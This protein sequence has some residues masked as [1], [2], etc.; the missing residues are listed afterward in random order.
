MDEYISLAYRRKHLSDRAT[1]V[2]RD[3]Q[4]NIQNLQQDI[5]HEW[6][7][8]KQSAPPGTEV[9]VRAPVND[10][11][12][13]FLRR[14]QGLRPGSVTPNR[15]TEF[16]S[17]SLSPR[18]QERLFRLAQ[19][20]QDTHQKIRQEHT[21]R[22]DRERKRQERRQELQAKKPEIDAEKEKKRARARDSKSARE[23]AKRVRRTAER[24]ARDIASS[25]E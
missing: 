23:Y 14:V 19:D 24:H 10:S 17:Q 21:V 15:V 7:M 18:T 4:Q 5:V 13:V 3:M 12:C 16:T 20:V 1:T 9:L 25:H 11:A 2:I 6:E 22:I 8:G